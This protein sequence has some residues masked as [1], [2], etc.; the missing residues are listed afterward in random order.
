MAAARVGKFGSKFRQY[1]VSDSRSNLKRPSLDWK[2]NLITRH[3]CSSRSN[4]STRLRPSLYFAGTVQIELFES[5]KKVGEKIG[6]VL[7]CV[8]ARAASSEKQ[9]KKAQSIVS[10]NKSNLYRPLVLES[11]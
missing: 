8:K 9:R 10:D 1:R 6:Q 7:S 4:T 3:S 2:L 11:D 5:G